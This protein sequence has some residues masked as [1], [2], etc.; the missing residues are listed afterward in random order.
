VLGATYLKV[1]LFSAIYSL[2]KLFPVLKFM[3]SGYRALSAL[4]VEDAV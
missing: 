4:I 2:Q 3:R 1:L